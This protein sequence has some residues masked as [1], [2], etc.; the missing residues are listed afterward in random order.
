MEFSGAIPWKTACR[1][2]F[3]LRANLGNWARKA[4]ETSVGLGGV[5]F[6]TTGSSL[7]CCHLLRG[8]YVSSRANSVTWNP[9]KMMGVLLQCS[10]ILVKEKVCT[11]CRDVPVASTSRCLREE[12]LV[13]PL[14]ACRLSLPALPAVYIHSIL[15]VGCPLPLFSARDPVGDRPFSEIL[16]G[17]L[18]VCTDLRVT[19]EPP[20][21]WEQTVLTERYFDFLVNIIVSLAKEK[22][23]TRWSTEHKYWVRAAGTVSQNASGRSTRCLSQ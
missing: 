6:K 2:H 21:Q 15:A 9:H 3:S 4:P 8:S 23:K 18:H 20:N 14:W 16:W 13:V 19:A 7:P 10:A 5:F 12:W 1:L 11:P 17:F 22:K